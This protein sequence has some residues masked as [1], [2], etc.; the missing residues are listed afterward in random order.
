MAGVNQC[1][2]S[3]V[4][5][6]ALPP[7][8]LESLSAA[9]NQALAAT[10]RP[11][12]GTAAPFIALS[13][14]GLPAS[15][16]LLCHWQ[17][18]SAL[19]RE[20]NF[21]EAKGLIRALPPVNTIPLAEYFS[22]IDGLACMD[23]GNFREAASRLQ[24][25]HPS[26]CPVLASTVLLALAESLEASL[27]L[28][29]A[30]E[31]FRKLTETPVIW[32]RK[33]AEYALKRLAVLR[34]MERAPQEQRPI[35]PLHDDRSTRGNWPLGYGMIFHLLAA[36][37]FRKDYSGG[38]GDKLTCRFR[39]GNPS[40]KGRLWVTSKSVNDA[41]ALWNPQRRTR[42]AANRDDHGEQNPLGTGPDLL[43][44]CRIPEGVHLLS[45]YFVN[46]YHY[47]EQN[48]A[49]TVTVADAEQRLLC[50]THVRNF[51]GGLY[52]RFAVSGPA[53]LQFRIWRNM[54]INVLLSGVFLDTPSLP[55][56][57]ACLSAAGQ[58]ETLATRY[59]SLRLALASA[60]PT[61]FPALL[62][63]S[64][65]LLD[66]L[67]ATTAVVSPE[68]TA[69]HW[70]KSQLLRLTGM[71]VHGVKA[72]EAALANYA[73]PEDVYRLVMDSFADRAAS[74]PSLAWHQPGNHEL[75][76]LWR[77]YFALLDQQAK[78]PSAAELL[79]LSQ[80][81]DWRVTSTAMR[82]AAQRLAKLKQL[83]PAVHLA[84]RL[85]M[86]MKIMSEAKSEDAIAELD[87][88]EDDAR[89]AGDE[90]VASRA[91]NCLLALSG[92]MDFAPD[93]LIRL[94]DRLM[95]A[96]ASEADCGVA[97]LRTAKAFEK[98]RKF[99]EA[100]VWLDKVPA[101]AI[102]AK[103]RNIL[104]ERWQTMEAQLNPQEGRKP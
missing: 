56:P 79:A 98:K 74:Q 92:R 78:P 8:K 45:L 38:L 9:W 76:I 27:E 49:Y 12:I 87:S 3:L 44:T 55:D 90:A 15:W 17:T 93:Q 23:E 97:A 10:Y 40:E 63:E 21:R 43:L 34:N 35:V 80:A 67:S 37:N 19:L 39:T 57:P 70:M 77:R 22:Y 104:L 1:L 101:A 86:A 103:G 29:Q 72:L 69:R 84:T 59:A 30:E 46:D 64:D 28:I 99:K 54:S 2:V 41:A 6:D 11:D 31:A 24:N 88:L 83:P 94:H 96:G 65:A 36:H 32:H 66:S 5:A 102:S 18:A 4:P 51:G 58:N 100:K 71:P 75:D 42:M 50:V 13:E 20:G 47:Y 52:K 73:A 33:E 48:R 7:E 16:R 62:A 60:T 82:E 91:R 81:D 68:S 61:D 26:A 53:S 14:S 85:C 25:C 89:Q 95:A